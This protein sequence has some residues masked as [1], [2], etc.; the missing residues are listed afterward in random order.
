MNNSFFRKN[1]GRMTN[2]RRALEREQGKQIH[3][4]LRVFNPEQSIG[5]SFSDGG[6]Q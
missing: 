6:Q 2:V 3:S 4:V 5:R 1:S